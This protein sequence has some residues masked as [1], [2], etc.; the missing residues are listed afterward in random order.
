MEIDYTLQNFED[1]LKLLKQNIIWPKIFVKKYK[2][3]P[4]EVPVNRIMNMWRRYF[5]DKRKENFLTLKIPEDIKDDIKRPQ[6]I[7]DRLM[8]EYAI[9]N[10]IKNA[11]NY[12]HMGSVI[13]AESKSAYS[14]KYK[15]HTR[16]N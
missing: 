16:T 12:S 9:S 11:L 3:N 6:P 10:L 5:S 2:I 13:Y 15:H 14:K 1:S 7:A 4:V 8:L